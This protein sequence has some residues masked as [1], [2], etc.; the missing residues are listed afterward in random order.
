M[1]IS[2]RYNFETNSSSMHS[3]SVR[4]ESGAYSTEE[5]RRSDAL[6]GELCQD[7]I[8]IVNDDRV[9]TEESIAR[10][11]YIHNN[12]CNIW[13]YEL[14]FRHSA[15][16]VLAD[17]RGKF[18][19]ALANAYGTEE[20]D[21]VSNARIDVLSAITDKFFPGVDFDIDV[22]KLNYYGVGTNDDMLFDYLDQR[23]I[24]MEEFL[25]NRKYI[26]IVNYAEYR[27]MSFLNIHFCM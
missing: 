5:L 10:G 6:I 1:P 13:E 18:Y 11:L 25:T 16:Q 17:F 19:Y 8:I 27:K 7:A 21:D 3:L 2:I 20:S 12:R 15:M 9:E 24:T 26:V 14:R 23:N 4:R 22:R